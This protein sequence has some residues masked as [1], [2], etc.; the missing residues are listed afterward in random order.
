[1]ELEQKLE[2]FFLLSSLEFIDQNS[3]C[4]RLKRK[5]DNLI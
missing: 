5:F 3:E 2:S 1:M 4:I